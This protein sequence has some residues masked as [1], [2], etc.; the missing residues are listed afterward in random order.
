HCRKS[1][2]GYNL[3]NLFV[4]SEGTLGVITG[5]TL[6]LH[7]IPESFLAV[8]CSFPSIKTATETTI[9]TL[10]SCVPVTKIELLDQMSM[11]ASHL[12]HK[13]DLPI[14]PTLF[15]EF[16][17]SKSDIEKQSILFKDIAEAN[18]CTFFKSTSNIEERN[19]LWKARH[20]MYY[21][22]LALKPN[23][24]AVTTDVCVPIS[25]LT[26]I[27]LW[28]QEQLEKMNILGPIVGHVGDGNF[29]ILA[30]IPE[31]EDKKRVV[32]FANQLSERCALSLG[33]TCTGE[34]GIGIGKKHLLMRH[35]F[36]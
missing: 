2:A 9:Q 24:S 8:V 19:K 15:V 13:S 7:P 33:G 1:V 14:A 6:K 5:L 3:T 31:K 22:C 20:E 26:D 32:E 16:N 18:G 27:V 29:H 23:C 36:N 12:Y 34:H 35:S 17:G 30:L 11:K 25:K 4:G 10:Q 28:S 21:A